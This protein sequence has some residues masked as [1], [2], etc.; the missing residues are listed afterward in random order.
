MTANATKAV[1]IRQLGTA[2]SLAELHLSGL[3][4]EEVLWEPARHGPRVHEVDGRWVSDWPDDE[5]YG[6]GVPTLAWLQWHIGMWWSI[7]TDRAFGSGHLVRGSIPWPGSADAARAWLTS[8]HHDW[9]HR[10]IE[11]NDD[12]LDGRSATWPLSSGRFGDVVA[13]VNA[14]LMKN[15]AEMGLLRFLYASRS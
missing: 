5:T 11:L 4:D 9:M 10:I 13:W 15:A 12:D 2:W 6:A 3:G 1:L 14:E 8:L 7:A